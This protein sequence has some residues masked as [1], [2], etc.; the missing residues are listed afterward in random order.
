MFRHI[1][2]VNNRPPFE[3]HF[4]EEIDD[5][6]DVVTKINKKNETLSK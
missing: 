3:F 2:E 5:Y 1:S 4:F 6:N